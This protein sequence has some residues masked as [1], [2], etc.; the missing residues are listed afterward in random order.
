MKKSLFI[1]FLFYYVIGNTQVDSIY[2]RYKSYIGQ[3]DA[4]Y[5]QIKSDFY[6]YLLTLPPDSVNSYIKEFKRF[7]SFW[8]S[9]AGSFGT[10]SIGNFSDLNRIY[11]SFLNSSVCNDDQFYLN[12]SISKWHLI[13]PTSEPGGFNIGGIN[14]IG[15]VSAVLHISENEYF[16]GTNASGIWRT[17]DGGLNWKC[18]T[19]EEKFFGIGVTT[20]LKDP[21]DITGK[22]LFAS[23]GYN[24]Y[25]PTYGIG[26]IK[27]IDG[28]ENWTVPSNLNNQEIIDV[29]LKMGISENGILYAITPKKI[30]KSTDGAN[31]W[32]EISPNLNNTNDFIANQF[33]EWIDIDILP[34]NNGNILFIS[35]RDFGASGGGAQIVISFDGGNTWSTINAADMLGYENLN[36]ITSNPDFE[37]NQTN[38]SAW[39]PDPNTWFLYNGATNNTGAVFP[40]QTG[41]LIQKPIPVDAR[42]SGKLYFDA[43]I[44]ANTK[45]KIIFKNTTIPSSQIEYTIFESNFESFDQT[46]TQL[47]IPYQANST[48]VDDIPI[49][50]FITAYSNS[51]YPGYQLLEID[52]F[53]FTPVEFK[54]KRLAVSCPDQ[55]S[56]WFCSMVENQILI[57][58][59]S[60][61]TNQ[62]GYYHIF[63]NSVISFGPT[64]YSI[65]ETKME[66]EASPYQSDIFFIGGVDFHKLDNYIFSTDNTPHDDIRALSIYGFENGEEQILSGT[67]GGI[68]QSTDGANTWL[69]KNG[70]LPITQFYGLDF[71]EFNSDLIVSGAIDNGSFKFE[72]NE[73]EIINQPT[74]KADGGNSKIVNGNIYY[75]INNKYK[76]NTT[77]GTIYLGD[78]WALNRPLEVTRELNP[79]VFIGGNSNLYKADANFNS[80]SVHNLNNEEVTAV[81]IHPTNQNLIYMAKGGLTWSYP[82]TTDKLYFS[83][84]K[85]DNWT[86]IS[87]PL[88]PGGDEIY[89]WFTVS[90]FTFDPDNEN[91]V[92][93]STRGN[94]S[95]E[96]NVYAKVFY[97]DD[98]GQTWTDLSINNGLPPFSVNTITRQNGSDD[99]LYAGTDVGVFYCEGCDDPQTAQWNCYN[100]ELPPCIVTD[101]KINYCQNKLYASTFGRAIWNVDLI[102]TEKVVSSDATWSQPVKLLGDLRITSGTTLVVN[103]IIDVPE[104]CKI[105]VENKA[106]LYLNGG[107]LTNSCGSMWNGVEVWGNATSAQPTDQ[108]RFTAINNSLIEHS[109]NGIQTYALNASGSEDI[110]TTGAIIR[111]VNSTFRNNKTAVKFYPYTAYPFGNASR[112][113]KCNFITDGELNDKTLL[114][115]EQVLLIGV[116]NVN[117]YGCKFE[118]SRAQGSYPLSDRGKGIRSFSSIFKVLPYN[119]FQSE[120]NG[121]YR[122]IEA[123]TAIAFNTFMVR[124]TKFN[125]CTRGILANGVDYATII[126]NEFNIPELQSLEAPYG[127]YMNYCKDYEIENNSFNSTNANFNAGLAVYNSGDSPNRI[128]D[129]SFDNIYVAQ[130]LMGDNRNASTGDGLQILCNVNTNNGYDAAITVQGEIGDNQGALGT[131]TS[132][133]GN[134][135]SHNCFSA[136]DYF[137]QTG[138]NNITYW[139]HDNIVPICY[140]SNIS[141]PGP[142]GFIFDLFN[143]DASCPPEIS[144]TTPPSA[145]KSLFNYYKNIRIERELLIDGGNTQ[146]VIAYITSNHS[147]GQI[148]NYLM[149]FSPYLSD[150]VLLKA[151]Q[152]NLPAGLIKQILLANSPLSNEVMDVFNSSAYPTGIINEVLDAQNG[153]SERNKLHAELAYYESEKNK[154]AGDYIRH[155]LLVDTTTSAADSIKVML[156][157]AGYPDPLCKKAAFDIHTGDLASASTKVGDL[158]TIDPDDAFCKLLNVLLELEMTLEKCFGITPPQKTK[159]EEIASEYNKEACKNAQSLLELVY[160]LSFPEVIEFPVENRSLFEVEKINSNILE[161]RS[162]KVYPNPAS[163]YLYVEI[164][165]ELFESGSLTFSIYDIIG[166]RLLLIQ[167]CSQWESFDV[168]KLASGTYLLQIDKGD[169]IIDKIKFIRE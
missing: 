163:D 38:L 149:D 129:N 92:W 166:K 40:S 55:N 93:C 136:N 167:A 168:S 77:G 39:F 30:Y 94:N 58:S 54:S 19:N 53:R 7:E 61:V 119:L 29:V 22:T 111:C 155:Y 102:K 95:S 33:H 128:Y 73:W 151:I 86:P 45:L 159:L 80:Y 91:R 10:N 50:M 42:Y 127:I 85:G 143:A 110:T 15:H 76:N 75:Q 14:N 122:G 56:V 87:I 138:I 120:F 28:G 60:P 152:L 49:R 106:H 81:G 43:F 135:F 25:G 147:P 156:S 97:S 84:D 79:F 169:E 44:P 24:T 31:S 20:I 108:G 161:N 103:S 71:E 6:S 78:D 23:T 83:T 134:R 116:R 157:L 51:D 101:L 21:T 107:T 145:H 104:N 63:E 65:S 105:I 109:I 46:I 47:E 11:R 148:K 34:N 162:I 52:N 74:E 117:F 70:K 142:N 96:T 99:I 5:Y 113:F 69:D 118:N 41:S 8:D 124:Q 1:L 27:S 131:Q 100:N 165:K 121:L 88:D 98:Y 164:E 160:K 32:N 114:P 158:N 12:N 89:H 130:L 3:P 9:R 57:N 36:L 153:I 37:L 126:E 150:E 2:Y 4:N 146:N 18:V 140:S 141:V 72:N 132:L 144:I 133:A 64:L 48:N 67:D 16:L 139:S 66:F 82:V 35:S 115:S 68:I 13:G 90:D 137:D 17:V 112:F 62:L 59:F 125:N 123:S 154:A 26:V